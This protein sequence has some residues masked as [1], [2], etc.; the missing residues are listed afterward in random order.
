MAPGW[1]DRDEKLLEPERRREMVVDNKVDGL[2]TSAKMRMPSE[3][4]SVG[5]GDGGGSLGSTATNVP[6]NNNS[7][8]GEELDRAFGGLGF[9]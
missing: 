4:G 2:M 8:E 7:N 9:R 3:A 1:L 5:G 6:P